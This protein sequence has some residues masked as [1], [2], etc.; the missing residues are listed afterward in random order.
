MSEKRIIL[1]MGTGNDLYGQD[2]TKAARRAVQ[3]AL[4]HSS[5]TLFSKLR[6][7]HS[8]MRVEVTIGVQ[9][10]EAVDCNLVAQDLPRGRASV[11][12]VKGGLDVADA[13]EGTRHVIATAA[14]EAWLPDQAGKYKTSTPE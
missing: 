8:E 3:D 13:E 14:V 10:P 6:L 12:A 11:R 7:D 5:I 1:E 2:Y 4:H 9:Q